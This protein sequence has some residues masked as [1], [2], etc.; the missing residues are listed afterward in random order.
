[1]SLVVHYH[2]SKQSIQLFKNN[3]KYALIVEDDV[4]FA[5]YPHWPIDLHKIMEEAPKD[6][7]TINLFSGKQEK[8][9]YIVCSDS[10]GV[11]G[12]SCLYY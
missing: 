7:N 8:D 5:L 6:W 11:Y 12:N 2:T 4:S 3:D 1:V 9:D 10:F